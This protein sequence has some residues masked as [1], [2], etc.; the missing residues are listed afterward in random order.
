MFRH[1]RLSAVSAC[2]VASVG[3]DGGKLTG[4]APP[5]PPSSDPITTVTVEFG[6][7]VVNAETGGPVGNV[8]VSA[9][10]MSYPVR[11]IGWDRPKN[12][13]TS[14]EDGTFTLPLNLPSLWSFVRLNLTAPAGYDDTSQRYEGSR[15][16]ADPFGP[17]AADRPAIR[18]YP[19][20]VI[21]PGESIEVRVDASIV[22]CGWDGYACRRVLVAASPGDSGELEV[23]SHD[24]SKPMALGLAIPGNPY[25]LEP[26]MSVRRLVVPPGGVPYVIGDYPTGTATLTMRR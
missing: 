22:W 13:A 8:Q 9:G 16:F 18:M 4:P 23:V 6:G 1:L 14:G 20:L 3:C 10:V 7:R 19:T 11:P 21:R 25:N 5:P 17:T 2:I 12:T 26:D 15:P 24:S